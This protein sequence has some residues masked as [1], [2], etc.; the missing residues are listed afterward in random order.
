[1]YGKCAAAMTA[2]ERNRREMVESGRIQK[3]GKQGK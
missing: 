2:E 1:M 3:I